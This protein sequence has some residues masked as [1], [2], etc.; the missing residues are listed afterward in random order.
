MYV[1]PVPGFGEAVEEAIFGVKRVYVVLGQSE[2]GVFAKNGGRSNG[3]MSK[4]PKAREAGVMLG[5]ELL[6]S[7]AVNDR[8]QW[9]RVA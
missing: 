5:S 3:K 6:T 2:G 8:V 1:S 7:F 4:R 9:R